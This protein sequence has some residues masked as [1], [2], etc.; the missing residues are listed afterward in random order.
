[1]NTP[2][3]PNPSNNSNPAPAIAL[4]PG[5]FDPITNGHVDIIS[6]GLCLFDRIIV[7][8]AVNPHK[9]P[10]F[11]LEERYALINE[12]FRDLDGRIEVG[13]TDGLIVDYARQR[14]ARA[15][16]RGLRAISDFDYEFQ[17][18]L[19]NRRLDRTVETVFLMTGFRWIYISSTGIKTTARLRGSIKGLVPAHVEL[20]LQEKFA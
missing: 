8:V 16:I 6:R 13:T 4:Y 19:M 17:M 1:M 20:A 12:C 11:S 10:L 7:T 18:A 3:T 9:T 15:I 2:L 5:T 14:G